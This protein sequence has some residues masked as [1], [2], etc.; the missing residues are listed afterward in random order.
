[1]NITSHKIPIDETENSYEINSTIK[2]NKISDSE[3]NNSLSVS[4]KDKKQ[5]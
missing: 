5:R 2:K 3:I 1:M 4:L